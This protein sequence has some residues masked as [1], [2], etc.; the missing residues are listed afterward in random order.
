[1]AFNFPR[2]VSFADE[3]QQINNNLPQWHIGRRERTSN[4]A[5]VVNTYFG[6]QLADYK[7]EEVRAFRNFFIQTAHLDEVDLIKVAQLPAGTDLSTPTKNANKL[8]N[9]AFFLR[10]RPDKVG[11]AWESTG[12][13]TVDAVALFGATSPAL[14]P[15]VSTSASV[16]QTVNT[17]LWPANS[18]RTISAWYRIESWA[19]GTVPSSSH[20]ILVSVT[21]A[22]GTTQVFRTA[23]SSDTDDQW[24]RVTLTV[25]PAKAVAEYDVAIETTRSAGFDIDVPVRV[26]GFQVEI[27]GTAQAW[28]PSI[29]DKPNW[30]TT[31]LV[32][33]FQLDADYP[34]FTT[35]NM[36]DFYQHGIPTRAELYKIDSIVSEANRG[37]GVR[38]TTDFFK[39][40]WSYTWDIDTT[41]NKVRKIGIEPQD[42]YALFDLGFFTQG[43]DGNV[44]ES[45]LSGLTYRCATLFGR[46]L[47]VVHDMVDI[48][49]NTVTALSLCD[50]DVPSPSPTYLES[51][52]TLT[53]PVTPGLDYHKL[54]IRFEDPQHLY[55][56]TPTAEF[57]L[58]LKYD[59]GMVDPNT[60]EVF[61]RESYDFLALLEQ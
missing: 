5:R 59:Y 39:S 61:L 29:F 44:Y 57:V 33:T 60:Y 20:G 51:R 3:T 7:R 46:W 13:V 42:I 23:L 30:F 22:D 14:R 28:R 19:G 52:Y 8:R 6:M 24:K 32:P 49:G 18:S 47:W 55:L 9:S 56:S 27:G 36:G 40:K 16:V 26:D 58:R 35:T 12:T 17:D 2:V 21:Y 1:M 53:L 34:V 37:G 25:T 54:E 45:G 48:E 50:P 43:D 4:W 15:A 38:T 11:D 31:P 10:A 41:N